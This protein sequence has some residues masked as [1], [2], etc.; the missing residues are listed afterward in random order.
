M[1]QNDPPAYDWN[2]VREDGP[3]TFNQTNGYV[4]DT[5]TWLARVGKHLSMASATFSLN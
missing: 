4:I 1:Q 5:F 2:Q 3:K